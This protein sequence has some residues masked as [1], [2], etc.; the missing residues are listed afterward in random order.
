[1]ERDVWEGGGLLDKEYLAWNHAIFQTVFTNRNDGQPVYL[2]LDDEVLNAIRKNAGL[3]SDVEIE[4]LISAVRRSLALSAAQTKIF[5]PISAALR[6]WNQNFIANYETAGPPPILSLLAVTVLA[7]EKMGS[8]DH[9]ANAYYDHLFDLLEVTDKKTRRSLQNGYMLVAEYYWDVLNRWLTQTGGIFGSKSA[10][11]ISHRYIGL[12]ISQALVRDIDRKKLPRMFST[13]M[14]TPGANVDPREMEQLFSLWVSREDSHVSNGLKSLWNKESAR[15]RISEVLCGEL[16]SWDGSYS[17]HTS[18]T[19]LKAENGLAATA[20]RLTLQIS[21]FPTNVANWGFGFSVSGEDPGEIHFEG[22]NDEKFTSTQVRKGFHILNGVPQPVFRKAIPAVVALQNEFGPLVRRTPKTVVV[23]QFDPEVQRFVE[24][25]QISLGQDLALLV[26]NA[27][28]L[29]ARLINF[30]NRN[31]RRGW[32]SWPSNATVPDGW[33]LVE[34]VQILSV[35]TSEQISQGFETLV[36]RVAGSQ[37]LLSGGVKIPGSAH[38][39]AWLKNYTPEIRALSQTEG[40][41]KIEISKAEWHEDS[42]SYTPIGVWESDSG[43]IFNSTADLQLQTGDYRVSFFEKSKLIQLREFQVVDDTT[44]NPLALRQRPKVWHSF[45]NGIHDLFF[46][47]EVQ[48]VSS[49]EGFAGSHQVPVKT[50]SENQLAKLPDWD[51]DAATAEPEDFTSIAF[52]EELPKCYST[53][54][55]HWQEDNRC[56]GKAPFVLG[57]C[58]YCKRKILLACSPH[59]AGSAF[60]KLQVE[61]KEMAVLRDVT[62]LAAVEENLVLEKTDWAAVVSLVIY[63]VHGSYSSLCAAITPLSSK[64]YTPEKIIETLYLMG[65]IEL[66]SDASGKPLG[67]S[68]VLKQAVRDPETNTTSLAGAWDRRSRALVELAATKHGVGFTASPEGLSFGELDTSEPTLLSAVFKTAKQEVTMCLASD[69]ADSL[70][71]LSDLVSQTQRVN[72]PGFDSFDRFDLVQGKWVKQDGLPSIG[73]L[74][75]NTKW[76]TRY[77]YVGP[78]DLPFG[79]GISCSAT[80]SKYIAANAD[81][82]QL[83]WQ[84]SDLNSVYAPY[85]AIP[86]GLYTRALI[87]LGLLL[88]KTVRHKGAVGNTDGTRAIKLGPNYQTL[89][90]QVTSKLAN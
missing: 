7:A 74:R 6:D 46:A 40:A 24:V 42:I 80:M 33:T 50:K 52:S 78:D 18:N 39:N 38:R 68:I 83:L 44:F 85:G 27:P 89:I 57:T 20:A 67:W 43:S 15:Q 75:L 77:F 51:P 29:Q 45:K 70:P 31:A 4:S 19:E 62:R 47:S 86:P 30:L 87:S 22:S 71:H 90:Q 11:S 16:E 66:T 3:P 76:G 10:Y 48:S 12:P 5:G 9:A 55:H 58:K 32:K 36:P 65:L 64:N 21:R 14:L 17:T 79:R 34:G 72:L 25:D 59:L 54:A 63:T 28:A 56:E 35:E 2:D 26:Q 88:P 53:G 60:S 41:I 1:M 8:G 49:F 84:G 37:V 81:G 13:L 82:Q 69:L 61:R 73:A 23:L